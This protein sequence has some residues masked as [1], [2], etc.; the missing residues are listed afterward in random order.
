MDLKNKN[1]LLI[2]MKNRN[3]FLNFKKNLEDKK[4]PFLFK[5]SDVLDISIV[6][7]KL[8]NDIKNNT[9]ISFSKKIR[10]P[11]RS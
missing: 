8:K 5:N 10:I 4:I 1:D 2:N 6:S 11:V 3:E 7:D 9:K